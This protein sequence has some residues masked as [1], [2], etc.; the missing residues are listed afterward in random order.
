V[1]CVFA[2]VV[3]H[4]LGHAL[5]ARR[6]GIRTRDITLL[7]IGGVARLEGMP[8]TPRREIVVAVAG[9]AV[10]VVI[11]AV[12]VALL[13]ALGVPNPFFEAVEGADAAQAQAMPLGVAAL[14][15]QVAMINIFLVL[16]NMIPAFPMDGGRVL[17]AVLAMGMGRGQATI[18][19]ARVG[20]VIAVLF[21]A[22]GLFLPV[23]PFLILIGI[24]VFFGGA[25]E[26]R[27]VWFSE[28][29][30]QLRVRD[31]MM[32]EFDT[33][34]A[35]ASLRHASE[36]LLA[37][38]QHQFPVVDGGRVV[39][40]LERAGLSA[41]LASLAEEAPIRAAMGSIGPVLDVNQPLAGAY[42]ALRAAGATASPVQDRG[43]FVGLLTLENVEETIE[44]RAARREYRRRA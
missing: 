30:A 17:R 20:Q 43:G 29:V 42:A 39:G 21:V 31:A 1:L 23:S 11:A 33:L 9:P 6:Y 35:D 22:A 16:F 13:V 37:G 5:A 27:A 38:S 19:A 4:E 14:L 40:L 25:N 10:N 7:P 32:T 18:A 34:E 15:W 41:A 26:V 28:T 36:R 44:L 8:E 12:L 24:F 3:L 2:C